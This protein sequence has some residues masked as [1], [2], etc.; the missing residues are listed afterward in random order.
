MMT[1]EQFKNNLKGVSM[2]VLAWN[3]KSVAHFSFIP[4]NEIDNETFEL[5]TAGAPNRDHF[6][7]TSKCSSVLMKYINTDFDVDYAVI[8]EIAKTVPDGNKGLAAEK[9]LFGSKAFKAYKN[10][11]IDGIL[12]GKRI[13]VKSSFGENGSG[14]SR[15]NKF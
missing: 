6:R 8:K 7:R 14:T 12:N 10:D 13:Q 15:S 5:I 9:Y 11:K 3:K 4:M 2:L 1:F